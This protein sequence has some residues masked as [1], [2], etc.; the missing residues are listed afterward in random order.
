[1][2]K[3]GSWEPSWKTNE[4]MMVAWLPVVAVEMETYEDPRDIL[5]IESIWYDD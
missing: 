3:S 1:M 4:I 5:E 2:N